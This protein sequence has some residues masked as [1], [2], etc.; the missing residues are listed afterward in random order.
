MYASVC[1]HIHDSLESGDDDMDG[2]ACDP[3]TDDVPCPN[4]DAP[5]DD[6]DDYEDRKCAPFALGPM[7]IPCPDTA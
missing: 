4:E 7:S 6:E 1:T 5:E 3:D 2:W